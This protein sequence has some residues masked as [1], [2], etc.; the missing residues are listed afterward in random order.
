MLDELI[1]VLRIAM[2]VIFF[3]AIGACVRGAKDL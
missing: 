2:F 3:V 1:V